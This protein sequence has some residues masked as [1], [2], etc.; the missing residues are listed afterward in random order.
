M[1]KPNRVSLGGVVAG[2]LAGFLLID[3]AK[4]MAL[5]LM[6]LPPPLIVI[7]GVAFLAWVFG[8]NIMITLPA[9]FV[10]AF[11]VGFSLRNRI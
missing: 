11:G 8:G 7:I 3:A 9:G 10:W 5:F 6:S 4:S 2:F 1:V